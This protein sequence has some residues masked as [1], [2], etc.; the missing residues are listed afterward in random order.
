MDRH[1]D[2]IYESPSVP[3]ITDDQSSLIDEGYWHDNDLVLA[4]ELGKALLDRNRKLELALEKS[5]S[6]EQ[7]KDAEIEMFKKYQSLDNMQRLSSTIATLEEQ[8]VVLMERLKNYD[9]ETEIS[10]PTFSS[11]SSPTST[12]FSTYRRHVL[13]INSPT[14]SPSIK[15]ML[16]SPKQNNTTLNS[17]TTTTTTTAAASDMNKRNDCIHYTNTLFLKN[18]LKSTISNQY[19]SGSSSSKEKMKLKPANYNIR[20]KRHASQY[21]SVSLLTEYRE[22]SGLFFIDDELFDQPDIG[23]TAGSHND[24]TNNNHNN[25][26]GNQ[27][28]L[29]RTTSTSSFILQS[30]FENYSHKQLS[31]NLYHK[32]PWRRLMMR[33]KRTGEEQ[34]CTLLTDHDDNDN[35]DNLNGT[36]LNT[37]SILHR[38]FSWPRFNEMLYTD[39]ESIDSPCNSAN[40]DN[41][42]Q[43]MLSPEMNCN[44]M[45]KKANH[46]IS[47]SPIRKDHQYE[48]FSNRC[49]V[50]SPSES[51]TLSKDNQANCCSSLSN[52]AQHN[53]QLIKTG[54]NNGNNNQESNKRENSPDNEFTNNNTLTKLNTD[55]SNAEVKRRVSDQIHDLLDDINF[56]S[57]LDRI[58]NPHL[59]SQYQ[60]VINSNYR[61]AYKELFYE[62]FNMLKNVRDGKEYKTTT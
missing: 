45:E 33:S 62:A 18:M 31:H 10:Y 32:T 7:E 14:S 25:A 28:K 56:V 11:T 34:Q 1:H 8:M 52:E 39:H 24:H 41:S 22:K 21:S 15:S 55:L 23:I 59:R 58:Y 9:H 47:T 43:D 26:A 46:D 48:E 5:K 4:A 40:C 2:E 54:D 6:T 3:S 53:D 36:L 20:N 12:P 49:Q 29:L 17:T 61:P 30:T 19:H 38:T 16:S 27:Q 42:L 37:S 44:L 60:D 35:T 57:C 50:N 51:T 13:Q